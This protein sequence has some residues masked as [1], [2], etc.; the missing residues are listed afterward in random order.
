MYEVSEAEASAL[1]VGLEKSDGPK[2]SDTP[3]LS[4]KLDDSPDA[5][6]KKPRKKN[7]VYCIVSEPEKVG[8]GLNAYVTYK[9][10]T[11]GDNDK[12]NVST[13]RYSDFLWLHD[14]LG[15]E[16]IEVIIPP[17]PEKVIVNHTSSDLVDY[18]RRELQKFLKRVLRHTSLNKS[19]YLKYFLT[20]SE[21]D[22]ANYRST[23]KQHKR[24]NLEEEK[25][26][27]SNAFSFLQS[28]AN[29]VLSNTTQDYS[30][31]KE[32]DTQFQETRQ[33]FF[34]LNTH[35]ETL[36]GKA[37]DDIKLTRELSTALMEFCHASD[38]MSK[39]E[40]SQDPALSGYW[41]KLAV[42]TRQMADLQEVLAKNETLIFDNTLRDYVRLTQAGKTTLN[43]RLDLLLK[44]QEAQKRNSNSVEAL[45]NEFNKVSEA[46]KGEV[47]AFNQ[48]KTKD[49]RNM[50]RALIAVNIEHHQ[51]VVALWKELLSEL[52]DK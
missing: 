25:G 28:T 45:Q 27:F 49:F 9:V 2:I 17:V 21:S 42:V 33:Y 50:L 16:F 4:I 5:Q 47:S 40:A 26:F 24:P 38:L 43:N 15:E 39:C 30:L 20:A 22:M 48:K 41:R 23:I 51:K 52:E 10:H 14:R 32:V 44:L 7:T 11:K 34:S 6:K 8:E 19:Q 12:P 29:Q 46:V 31:V 13:R 36:E 35:F 3:T 37:A 18:R 1:G